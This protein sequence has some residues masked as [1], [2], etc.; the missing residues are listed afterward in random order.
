MSIILGSTIAMIMLIIN[1][2]WRMDSGNVEEYLRTN[3]H[4]FNDVVIIEFIL[5]KIS[6]TSINSNKKMKNYIKKLYDYFKV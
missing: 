6:D 5:N 2:A 4:K 3:Y 1:K